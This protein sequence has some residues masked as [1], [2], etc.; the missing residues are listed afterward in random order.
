MARRGAPGRTAMACFR[1]F[2]CNHGL[3]GAT[4]KED[5]S[6]TGKKWTEAEDDTLLRAVRAC[7]TADWVAVA[8]L[9]PGR[10]HQDCLVRFRYSI[11]PNLKHGK[12]TPE[13]D[14][15]LRVNVAKYGAHK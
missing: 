6:A 13:E 8:N 12:W 14:E 4:R 3:Q 15:L 9:V 1:Y 5:P 7:G 11:D 10:S 2:K